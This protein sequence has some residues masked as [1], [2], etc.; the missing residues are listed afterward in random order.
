MTILWQVLF[1]LCS[2]VIVYVYAG[3]PILIQCLARIMGKNVAR[4]PIQPTVTI[5]IAA[6]NEAAGIRAK[7]DNVSSLEYS[8]GMVDVIV[9]SDASS[10]A[11]DEIVRTYDPQRVRLVRVEG[12]RG[13]TA[14]QNAAMQSATGEIVVFTDA[15]TRIEAHALNALTANFAD[16]SVG[17]AAGSLVY[18]TAA[19][20]PTGAGGAAYWSYEV[21]LRRAESAL[22][23]LVGVSGCLYAVRRS[24]YRAIAPELIS[25]FVIALQLREQGLRTVLEPAAVCFEDTLAQPGQELAMRVRVAVR[26]IYALVAERRLLNPIRYGSFAWQLWSHKVLRYASPLFWIIALATSLALAAQPLYLALFA[27]QILLILAGMAGF[28]LQT[29]RPGLL[30]KPYYFLLT[31]VASLLA[32]FRYARGERI[33]T[34][35]PI[36]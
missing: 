22:G 8:A 1:W 20:N 30:T 24:A 26:T 32:I 14:C 9:T 23:S 3:Y 5:V 19:H 2:C 34:W 33:V 12:R 25:D 18:E 16:L 29:K 13:K 10:D 4:S 7:L 21:K 15:T 6:Y 31:N 36:R 27:L 17:C 35:K 11:T 28:V